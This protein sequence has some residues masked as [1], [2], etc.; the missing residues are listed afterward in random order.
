M[1]LL[2]L[3]LVPNPGLPWSLCSWDST[4][5]FVIN[6]GQVKWNPQSL[7]CAENMLSYFLFKKVSPW[8]GMD[9]AQNLL[10]YNKASQ[11]VSNMSKECISSSNQPMLSKSFVQAGTSCRVVVVMVML[12]EC[13]AQRIRRRISI[14]NKNRGSVGY[15]FLIIMS[16]EGGVCFLE[17]HL[18][19]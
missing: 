4:S 12:K 11:K 7:H 2:T 10:T 17:R 3:T 5:I 13:G 8:V 19:S 18:V 14:S 15:F 1:P 16:L 6:R 9:P